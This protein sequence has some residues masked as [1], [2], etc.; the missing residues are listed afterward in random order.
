MNKF[1]KALTAISLIPVF[2]M[3]GIALSQTVKLGYV[4]LKEVFSKY[5]RANEM[6]AT[7]MKEVKA[8]QD[9]VSKLENKIKNAQQDFE[10]KKDI[11]KPEEKA[12]KETE[13]RADI[14]E[15][16]KMWSEVN[17][18]LDEKRKDI[19]EVLLDE[20]KKEV[21][22][23]GEKNGFTAILD[24]RVVIYGQEVVNLTGKIIKAVNKGDVKSK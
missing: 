18:K 16:T 17:K 1:K 4:D 19:E 5:T 2:A 15:F 22:K 6:E 8:E 10:K 24:S 14:Q 9:K 7:F 12:K 20:I 21:K 23:Y 11:M 3:P 13:L